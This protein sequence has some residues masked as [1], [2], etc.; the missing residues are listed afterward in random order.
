M[1]NSKLIEDHLLPMLVVQD[2]ATGE[3]VAQVI[4][5]VDHFNNKAGLT[6]E[7]KYIT[8]ELITKEALALSFSK[9]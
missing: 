7:S 5:F 4:N 3:I 6:P 1:Q 9:I 2:V 8:I